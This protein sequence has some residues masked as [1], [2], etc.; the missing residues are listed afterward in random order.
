MAYA[1][2]ASELVVLVLVLVLFDSEDFELE[3]PSDE[4]DDESPFDSAVVERFFPPPLRLSV[5]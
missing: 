3:E 5:L 1:D 4:L 2:L